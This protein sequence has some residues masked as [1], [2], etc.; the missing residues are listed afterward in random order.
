MIRHLLVLLALVI[1]TPAAAAPS[2]VS[3]SSGSAF[4]LPSLSIAPPAGYA[5]DDI[6]VLVVTVGSNVSVAA[7]SGWTPKASTSGWWGGVVAVYWRRATSSEFS[8]I[9]GFGG[10]GTHRAGSIHAFRG[11]VPWGDPFEAASGFSVTTNGTVATTSISTVTADTLALFVVGAVLEDR[12]GYG[13]FGYLTYPSGPATTPSGSGDGG[14]SYNYV[15]QT[16]WRG[17]R[18]SPGPTGPASVAAYPGEDGD[19]HAA[20]ILLAL[21]PAALPG[22][23]GSIT[24]PASSSGTYTIGW[25]PP[26][27]P[28]SRYEL[29]EN[30][31]LAFSGMALSN[32]FTGKLTGTYRYKVRA[33]NSAGCGPFTPEHVLTVVLVVPS[34]GYSYDNN[35]NLHGTAIMPY[36]P[37]CDAFVTT[38]EM[39]GSCTNRCE[40]PVN[41][42]SKC[43]WSCDARSCSGT[44]E[45]A[46]NLGYSAC[47]GMCC[48][49]NHVV[50]AT[51][52]GTPLSCNGT[53]EA[54]W[55]DCD[56]NKQSNGCEGTA[57]QCLGF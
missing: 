53:C 48:S 8:M 24:G 6:F 45:I 13:V 4:S 26:G 21:T 28:V 14:D 40:S 42:T 52:G 47:L 38:V 23:P 15:L 9:S 12:M 37:T 11:A 57:A 3:T 27:G 18:P 2:Y 54:G 10:S 39:C 25:S 36:D 29:Y 49:T 44:C 51:C 22:A 41:G 7:P 35:G 5:A 17:Y 56:G 46:C 1:A 31:A 50:A 43:A 55:Y 19:T 34:T 32:S 20:G 16:V 30:G 33:C